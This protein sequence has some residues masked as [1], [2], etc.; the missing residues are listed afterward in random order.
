MDK[1]HK[2]NNETIKENLKLKEELQK[3]RIENKS[4]FTQ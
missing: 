2:K 4:L 1:I 3:L